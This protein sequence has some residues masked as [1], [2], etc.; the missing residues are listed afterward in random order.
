V[1][2]FAYFKENHSSVNVDYVYRL[3]TGQ[4][5]VERVNE[6]WFR[7]KKGMLKKEI[8]GWKIEVPGNFFLVAKAS[9]AN[10]SPLRPLVVN[11]AQFPVYF[12]LR[13]G[14]LTKNITLFY[15]NTTGTINGF[16]FPDDVKIVSVTVC[17]KTSA[18]TPTGTLAEVNLTSPTVETQPNK[19][20]TAASTENTETSICGPGFILLAT[21]PV[22]LR[23]AK[24]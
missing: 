13:K 11:W 19:T 2:V 15:I 18:N 24:Q 12:T 22:L 8:N 10:Q 9:D 3:D 6:S 7:L 1:H 20:E 21:I 14:N 17:K 5:C 23:R 16:W 4:F